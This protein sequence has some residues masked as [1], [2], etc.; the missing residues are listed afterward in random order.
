MFADIVTSIT[1]II[2]FASLFYFMAALW[3]ARS[4][5]RQSGPSGDFAPGVSILKPL[6]GSDAEMYEA[7]ASHCRQNYAGEF[8]ILFGVSEVVDPAVA[9]VERLKAEY[10]ERSIRLILCPEDLG[11]NGKIS[12]VAQ[13]AREARFDFLIVN[14]SDIHVSPHYLTRIMRRFGAAEREE[15][16]GMVTA[17]YRG[18]AHGTLGS[19]MEALGIATDFFRACSRL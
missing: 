13:M 4:F 17:P 7:F 2:T 15:A 1:T 19:K 12:N 18:I 11:L 10:P 6:K 3:S 5:V 8:E 16:V 14:D 9:A